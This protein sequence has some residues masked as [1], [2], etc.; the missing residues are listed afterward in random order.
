MTEIPEADA[1]L[2]RHF[3]VVSQKHSA[4]YRTAL[5]LGAAADTLIKYVPAGTERTAGLRK[6]LEARDCMMRAFDD[7]SAAHTA[8][9]GTTS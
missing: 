4:R 7:E 8:Q 1:Q 5:L 6:L 9:Q 2:L 3:S